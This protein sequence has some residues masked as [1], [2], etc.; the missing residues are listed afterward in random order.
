MRVVRRMFCTRREMT[1]EIKRTGA[2]YEVVCGWD[3]TSS[4]KIQNY[5]LLLFEIIK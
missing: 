5:M 3:N 1:R 4:S 2:K